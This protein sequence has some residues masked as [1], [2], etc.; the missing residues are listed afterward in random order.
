MKERERERERAKG[1]GKGEEKGLRQGKRDMGCA[2][3]EKKFDTSSGC[4]DLP[5]ASSRVWDERL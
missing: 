5:A 1:N 2:R 4:A 3:R